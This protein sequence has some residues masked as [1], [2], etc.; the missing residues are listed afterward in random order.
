[1]FI[2]H[3]LNLLIHFCSRNVSPLLIVHPTLS[4]YGCTVLFLDLGPF[5]SFLILYTV[6]R[7][8]WMGDQPVARPLPTQRTTQ[9]HNKRT[10]TSMP[11]V[12]FEPTTPASSHSGFQTEILYAF[13][14][15][16]A[17]VTWYIHS[18]SCVC[19]AP[20]YAVFTVL[21]FGLACTSECHQHPLLKDI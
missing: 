12:D 2:A 11:W 18:T 10:Q 14:V 19:E 9:T 17:S 5:F 4:I 20:W 8:P 3:S 21:A 1:M 7:T 13:L 16:P 15:S 6:D